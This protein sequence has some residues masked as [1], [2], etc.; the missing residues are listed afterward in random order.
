M[1]IH[2]LFIIII[3]Y[4]LFIY[5]SKD[6]YLSTDAEADLHIIMYINYGIHILHDNISIR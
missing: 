1:C 5:S 2:L 4:Y 3:I 6:Q